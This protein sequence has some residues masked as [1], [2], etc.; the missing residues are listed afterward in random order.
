MAYSQSLLEVE[1][2]AYHRWAG[3][4]PELITDAMVQAFQRW[5]CVTLVSPSPQVYVLRGRIIRFLHSFEGGASWGEVTLNFSL[6][7]GRETLEERTFTSRIRARSDT[8][9]G[10]AQALNR[11]LGRVF[12]QLMLW[13]GEIWKVTED[14]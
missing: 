8:P 13:L 2:Y 6:E 7:H 9:Q 5:G 10:G 4:L 12:T 11:A 14:E 1:F 3:P